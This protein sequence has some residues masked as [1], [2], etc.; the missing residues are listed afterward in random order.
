MTPDVVSIKV[1]SGYRLDAEFADGAVR[2]FDM[3]PYL[4][5]PAFAALR[6]ERLFKR[7][8]VSNGTVSWSDEI[9]LS[10]DTLYLRGENVATKEKSATQVK[11]G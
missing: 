1:L 8:V 11:F 2:R 9:D 3:R 6:D 4:D 10:P 5:Y 7:A